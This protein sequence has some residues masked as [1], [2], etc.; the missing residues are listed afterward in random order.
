ME[1][2]CSNGLLWVSNKEGKLFQQKPQNVAKAKGIYSLECMTADEFCSCFSEIAVLG[3]R[4]NPMLLKI[5]VDGLVFNLLG[6]EIISGHYTLDE[7]N[8][9]ISFIVEKKLCSDSEIGFLRL[10]W[11]IYESGHVPNEI[12][13][14]CEK[15]FVEG[16]EPFVTRVEQVGY[17]LIE[18]LRCGESS[19]LD[20][21]EKREAFFLY[22]ALQMF[23]VRKFTDVAEHYGH[24]NAKT[25]KL[26]R[27]VLV[28]RTLNFLMSN[29]GNDEFCIV[30][31]M[32]DLEFIT[33]DN[34]ICNL[35]AY[36]RSKYIDLYFPIA[37]NMA[38]FI[39]NKDRVLL[40]PEM[41][42]MTT[43]YVHKL[44]RKIAADCT[45][46]VFSKSKV[47]L[48]LGGYRPSF[49]PKTAVLQGE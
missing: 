7:F 19:F 6:K 33:G 49:D 48:Q 20:D 11:A 29:F 24:I 22:I 3:T 23:R 10:F 37:P 32:T 46:Q 17:P 39:C 9:I 1:A 30:D 18:N 16:M 4:I 44:N 35:G 26:S 42:Q 43:H 21:P 45:N 41:R 34:P 27:L 47:T 40:Y 2:W 14:F 8:K 15:Q 31:N 12:Q 13:Q 28:S 25:L 5:I 38:V 36:R